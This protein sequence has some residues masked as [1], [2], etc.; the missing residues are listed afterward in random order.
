MSGP[1]ALLAE[2]ARLGITLS[3]NGD[4][5]RIEAPTGTVTPELRAQ[6]AA[7]K[8]AILA[9]L[10]DGSPTP[11][12]PT[13]QPGLDA[14]LSMSLADF[15]RRH[16]ALRIRLPDGSTCWFC[17][18][19]NE[20]AALRS[21]GVP[22]GAIWTARELG[23]VLGAGWTK[24]TIGRLIA[25]KREFNGMVGPSNAPS[26]PAASMTAP[27]RSACPCCGSR[28]F[29]RSVHGA[30]VCSTCHPPAAESLVVEWID[31]EAPGA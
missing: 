10:R 18:G 15:G 11:A 12:S 5:L 2:V 24:E 22:R 6:L 14:I 30:T 17:S 7:V 19:P 9:R 13:P 21:E 16:L 8:P 26:P 27:S 4:K 23:D 3:V 31:A 29:W 28:R 25:V 20:V 1:D